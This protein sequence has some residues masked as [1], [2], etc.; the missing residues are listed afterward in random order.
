LYYIDTNGEKHSF[1][2]YGIK[3]NGKLVI[4]NPN[5]GMFYGN[6]NKINQEQADSTN[7]YLSKNPS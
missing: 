3:S 5:G 1:S 4:V 7:A 2:E 6:L